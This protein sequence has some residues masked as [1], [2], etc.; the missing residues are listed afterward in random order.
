MSDPAGEWAVFELG[1]ERVRSFLNFALASAMSKTLK[2]GESQATRLY[3]AQGEVDGSLTCLDPY[4]FQPDAAGRE[5]RHG[6]S[7][8]ARSFRWLCLL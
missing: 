7:L 2:P 5:S 8:A 3:T 1:G 6:G 4:R